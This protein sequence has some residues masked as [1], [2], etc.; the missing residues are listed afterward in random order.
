MCPRTTPQREDLRAD[1]ET[2]GLHARL[3][4][5]DDEPLV[6]LRVAGGHAPK[7]GR[8]DSG[9]RNGR[10]H[11]DSGDRAEECSWGENEAKGH[12]ALPKNVQK[13]PPNL[14]RTENNE[15]VLLL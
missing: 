11:L 14:E 10:L 13:I 1:L 6:L 4:R 7:A 5:H 12:W 15:R 2:L 9:E 8:R 3:V